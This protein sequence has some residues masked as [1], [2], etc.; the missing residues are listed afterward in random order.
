MKPIVIV[1]LGNRLAGDDAIGPLV[2]DAFLADAR[3]AALADVVCAGTDL[4]RLADQ[5]R[6][7]ER[8]ILVDAALTT[9]PELQVHASHHPPTALERRMHAHAL[10]PVGAMDLLRALDP[11]VAAT[12]TWW[13]L[14]DVPEV[15]LGPGVS[16]ETAAHVPEAV[17]HLAHL[18][19]APAQTGHTPAR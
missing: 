1:A 16:A 9:E 10:D 8:I 12:E 2:A 7:R 11:R 5:L 15:R 18:V 19:D 4:F 14:I 6:G 13:L 3:L 17:A